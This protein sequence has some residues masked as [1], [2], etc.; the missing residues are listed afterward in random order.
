MTEPDLSIGEL[1]PSDDI[2][3]QWMFSLSAVV[4]DL[5]VLLRELRRANDE[6]IRMMLLFQRLLIVR[7]YEARKLVAAIDGRRELREFLD[8][9]ALPGLTYLRSVYLPIG[10]S[11]VEELYANVRHHGVHYMWPGSDELR[12]T[13]KGARGL[14]ARLR[15]KNAPTEVDADIRWVQVVAG[16]TLFGEF[17]ASQWKPRLKE[18]ADLSARIVQAW[19]ILHME[20]LMIYVHERGIALERFVEVDAPSQ[21]APEG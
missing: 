10:V 19:T 12:D 9:K 7:L 16:M 18:R 3:A 4:D 21:E 8:P 20:L 1:Y 11:V 2:V 13:L 15:V 14:P 17:S 5:T 6:D